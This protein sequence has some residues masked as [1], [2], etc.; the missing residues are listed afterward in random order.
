MILK[1][2]SFSNTQLFSSPSPWSRCVLRVWTCSSW[3]VYASG[4]WSKYFSY[5]NLWSEDIILCRCSTNW[6]KN[7]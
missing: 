4:D 5:A 1:V 2:N 3:N 7:I 6:S